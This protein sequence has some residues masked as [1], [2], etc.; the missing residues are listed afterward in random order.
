MQCIYAVSK[1]FCT[2]SSQDSLY[3]SVIEWAIS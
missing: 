3:T 1:C 2:A